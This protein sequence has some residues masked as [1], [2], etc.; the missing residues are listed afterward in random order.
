MSVMPIPI[1]IQKTFGIRYRNLDVDSFAMLIDYVSGK[2]A[3]PSADVMQLPKLMAGIF[4]RFKSAI[5]KGVSGSRH[6]CHK[7]KIGNKMIDKRSSTCL[8]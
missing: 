8:P 7:A 4:Y 6:C 5:E 1:S 3:I 2:Q